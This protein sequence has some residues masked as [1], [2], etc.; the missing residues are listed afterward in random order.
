MTPPVNA[1]CSVEEAVEETV[2]EAVEETE[3][4]ESGEKVDE[5]NAAADP[6]NDGDSETVS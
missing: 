4:E 2:E 1:F 3:E 6:V 5:L